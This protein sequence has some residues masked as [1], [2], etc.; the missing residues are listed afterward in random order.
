MQEEVRQAKGRTNV[1]KATDPDGIPTEGMGAA[2]KVYSTLT[3]TVPE[4]GHSPGIVLAEW[5][6]R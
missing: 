3:G 5:S 4:Q 1:R 6:R 2:Q